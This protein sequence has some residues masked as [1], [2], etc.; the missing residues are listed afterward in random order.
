MTE[1]HYYNA[2]V[3][4]SA[5]RKGIMCSPEWIHENGSCIEV[6]TPPELPK[7]ISEIW[8]PEHYLGRLKQ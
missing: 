4:S 2:D 3:T 8:S 5:D 6:A 7:G 1:A